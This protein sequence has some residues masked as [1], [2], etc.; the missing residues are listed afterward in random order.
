[1]NPNPSHLTRERISQI[2][3]LFIIVISGAAGVGWFT[4]ALALKGIGN[5]YIPMAPNSAALFLLSGLLLAKF[6]NKSPR[7][8]LLTR[9]VAVLFTALVTTRLSEYLTGIDLK[10]DHWFLTFRLNILAWRRSAKWLF[11]QP[12]HLCCLVQRFFSSPCLGGAGQTTF[13][14]TISGSCVHRVDVLTR[15]CLRSATDV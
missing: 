2:C 12:L 11:L 8:L 5:N 14:G 3:G 13:Q 1:M 4:G 7:F 9:V 6:T 15:I 10:V